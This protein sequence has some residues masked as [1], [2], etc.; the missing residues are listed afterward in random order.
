[1]E[2]II[3]DENY[4]RRCLTLA[5]MGEGRV[6]PSP[7]VG[8]ILVYNNRIISEGYHEIFGGTHAE[9]N[10]INKLQ[11]QELLKES[12]L[13][14]NLE[15]CS[16]FGKTP[17]C[18]NLII[19]S[20]IPKIF[21]GCKDPNPLVSGQGIKLLL[22]AG[23]DIRV[24]VLEQECFWLN[25]KF[26]TFHEKKRTYI[27]LKWA[28][29]A[30]GFI[31]VVRNADASSVPT[32]ITNQ[33][34][35]QLVHKWRSEQM[36]IMAGTNTILYDN[37]RLTVR[38][39]PGKN[40]LRVVIDRVLRLPAENYVFDKSIPTIVITEKEKKSE[41]NLE[42]CKIEFNENTPEKIL[43]ILYRKNIQSVLIEGGAMLLQTFIDKGLWDEARVF[44]GKIEFRQGIYAPVIKNYF[45]AEETNIG[46]N[47]LKLFIK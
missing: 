47:K 26:L 2:Q 15:P 5:K 1:M 20:K 35:K 39:W 7:L 14:V 9:A 25:R 44:Y 38:E 34:A 3:S 30:D 23:L 10:A 45:M 41:E 13:Y 46:N 12:S 28:Q 24:G 33:P 18:V 21:I 22:E 42:F 16:H 17:P 43:G 4:M 27:T 40:P 29:S 11:R 32:W 6:Q 37:P 8:A 31:D 19:S 36:A